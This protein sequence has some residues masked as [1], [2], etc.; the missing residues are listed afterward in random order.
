MGT[1][2]TSTALAHEGYRLRADHGI[3][4]YWW[5]YLAVPGVGRHW[6]KVTGAQ[7]DGRLFQL[8]VE[9]PRGAAP[10]VHIHRDAD[11]TFYVLD[12]EVTVFVGDERVDCTVGDFVLGPRGITHT[13]LVRS[14]TAKMLVTFSPAGVEKFFEETAPPMI[15]GQR[16][17][18]PTLD[19][20]ELVGLMAKH[21][22]EFIAPPPTLEPIGDGNA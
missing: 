3:R 8:V 4:E 1:T 21:Q 22:V 6:D 2:E 17:P 11:E 18:E 20:A 12:G 10:P 5:L 7:T 15:D 13:F 14:T 19:E 9:Y 16:A